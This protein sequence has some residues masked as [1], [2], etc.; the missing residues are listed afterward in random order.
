M[1]FEWFI[2]PNEAFRLF[3]HYILCPIKKLQ[4]P[5]FKVHVGDAVVVAVDFVV[6]FIVDF[7]VVGVTVTVVF[8]IDVVLVV[9][10]VV[11]VV[12]VV[13]VYHDDDVYHRQAQL[14][15]SQYSG[16]LTFQSHFSEARRLTLAMDLRNLNYNTVGLSG[17]SHETLGHQI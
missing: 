6:A 1:N 16:D 8:V 13:V 9:V 10:V 15:G 11:V 3:S 4:Y 14:E 17:S 12:I 2:G 7:F 5:P